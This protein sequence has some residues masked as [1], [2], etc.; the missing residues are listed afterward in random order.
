M[1]SASIWS[2][3]TSGDAATGGYVTRNPSI[4]VC[5]IGIPFMQSM[6]DQQSMSDTPAAAHIVQSSPFA[7]DTLGCVHIKATVVRSIAQTHFSNLHWETVL[8]SI[9]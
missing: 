8:V 1:K 5:S 4:L 2:V 3:Q 7:S 9:K 6:G